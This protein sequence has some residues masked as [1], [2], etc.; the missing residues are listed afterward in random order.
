MWFA[1]V[2]NPLSENKSSIKSNP[3]LAQKEEKWCD[4]IKK[5]I[6]Y[7]APMGYQRQTHSCGMKANLLIPSPKKITAHWCSLESTLKSYKTVFH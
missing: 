6:F 1:T 7:I 2:H 3:L 4:K 5:K